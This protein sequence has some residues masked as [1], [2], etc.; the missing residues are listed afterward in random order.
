MQ[1]FFTSILNSVARFE[2]KKSLQQGK[3]LT[4]G[5]FLENE[6]WSIKLKKVR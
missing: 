5:Y 6:H 4:P 3:M 1:N 2:I